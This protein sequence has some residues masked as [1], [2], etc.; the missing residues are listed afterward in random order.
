MYV[1]DSERK[2]CKNSD[3]P[4]KNNINNSINTYCVIVLHKTIVLI[5]KI[6]ICNTRYCQ[7]IA[8]P[9]GISFE[10]KLITISPAF[11]RWRGTGGSG[12][13]NNTVS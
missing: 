12:R 7:V 2:L 3:T 9:V 8:V 5:K 10:S 13:D 11:L 1:I 4:H 6:A